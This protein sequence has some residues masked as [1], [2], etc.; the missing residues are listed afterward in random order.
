MCPSYFRYK[1]WYTL[2]YSMEYISDLI[3]DN[4]QLNVHLS[5]LDQH[6]SQGMLPN[7]MTK[8]EKDVPNFFV[9]QFENYKE[10]HK[11]VYANSL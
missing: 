6:S 7:A 9:S 1:T 2:V 8:T 5:N 10:K 3:N 4:T 11:A